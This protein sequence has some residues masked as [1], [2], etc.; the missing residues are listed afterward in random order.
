MPPRDARL[1]GAG[2]SE[3]VK[4][5]KLR[6]SLLL[7]YRL[8]FKLLRGGQ[9]GVRQKAMNIRFSI[10]R[11]RASDPGR[12]PLSAQ[13]LARLH[14]ERLVPA[15]KGQP[16]YRFPSPFHP[17]IKGFARRL[18]DGDSRAAIVMSVEPLLV[19][20]YTDELDCVAMLRFPQE[21]ADEHGLSPGARLLTVNG[22]MRGDTLTP[23]LVEGPAHHGRY[24]NFIPLIAEFLSE[25]G[26]RIEFRKQEITEAEWQRTRELGEAY[27]KRPEVRVRDGRPLYSWF[28]AMLSAGLPEAEWRNAGLPALFDRYVRWE[29]LTPLPIAGLTML[30]TALWF[31]L[32]QILL[33][34]AQGRLQPAAFLV[35]PPRAFWFLPAFF[36]GIVCAGAGLQVGM[37]HWLGSA[38]A[39]FRSFWRAKLPFDTWKV[40]EALLTVVVPVSLFTVLLGL[41]CYSRFTPQS[42]QSST[43][44]SLSRTEHPYS[45]VAEVREVEA[46][47]APSGKIVYRPYFEIAFQDGF[48]WSSRDLF[49]DP[50]FQRDQAIVEFV[51]TKAG[52]PIVHYDIR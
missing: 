33:G 46:F 51:A 6:F 11:G 18:W 14:P 8:E 49:H 50:N 21:L 37:A 25:D 38:Y 10:Q 31:Q 40:F 42:L 30:F 32:F 34:V 12:V 27:L 2:Y 52:K 43:F 5:Q 17:W 36:L 1:D 28:P 45:A 23:D 39:G 47:Q 9:G 7:P 22:Y 13:K 48:V 44:L 20:A 4:T 24:R 41:D 26:P 16:G 3:I 35:Q 29:L 15:G 19:A